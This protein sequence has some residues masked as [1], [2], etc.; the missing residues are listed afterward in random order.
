[1]NLI[2]SLFTNLGS[3]LLSILYNLPMIFL[4]IIGLCLLVVF[5]EFGHFIFCKIFNVYTPSFSIGFGPRLFEKKIGD[6]VFAISAIPLGGYVE[7][8]GA[9]EVGQG[10]QTHAHD[11]NSR[12]F[13]QKPYWQ[14]MLIIFGGVLFNFIFTYLALSLLFYLGSPCISSLCNKYPAI[15][16]IIGKNSP[17]EKAGLKSNDK[18]IAVNNIKIDNIKH[19][20]KLLT[21][22]ID[23]T[24]TLKVNRD[25]KEENLDIKIASHKVGNELRP[26]IGAYWLVKPMTLKNALI[27]G[28][29]GTM[30]MISEM[31]K[32]LKNLSS[33][34]EQ[35]GGPLLV[36]TQL[37]QSIG[38]GWKVFI[39]MLAFI[40]INLA[41]LNIIPL[42]IFDGGQALF[43]TIEAITGKP[44]SDRLR[45]NIHYFTWIAVI[46]LVIYITYKD[47]LKLGNRFFK[48]KT[49]QLPTNA[50]SKK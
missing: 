10:D 32:S 45:Y 4:G 37:S 41:V 44:L 21:P 1:M 26:E 20:N 5:H 18:I 40:S 6:T 13:S 42:P 49:E 17:A 29:K 12:A 43:Y 2:L 3:N 11:K 27:A 33:N 46:L 50:E 15:V 24:V 7:I 35:L 14:K 38:L 25:G 47:I 16:S 30:D 31:L 23:K 28:F 19:L 36:I 9:Q 8:A 48:T 39:F 34:R 22:Y